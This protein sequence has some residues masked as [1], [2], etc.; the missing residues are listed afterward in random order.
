VEPVSQEKKT[1][2]AGRLAAEIGLATKIRTFFG[3]FRASRD[4]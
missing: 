3:I 4:F 2:M 1:V